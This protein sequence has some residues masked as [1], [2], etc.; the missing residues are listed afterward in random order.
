[1]RRNIALPILAGLL[2][3][4]ALGT[5]AAVL[6]ST[7]AVSAYDPPTESTGDAGLTLLDVLLLLVASVLELVG[8][9]IDPSA[10]SAGGGPGIGVLFVL[11][12]VFRSLA[13]PLLGIAIGGTV[14]LL[15]GRRLPAS[16]LDT[17]SAVIAN[18]TRTTERTARTNTNANAADSW[19]PAEPKTDVSDA[20]VTMTSKLEAA[21][22]HA[23]TPT[24]WAE[25]AITAGYDAAAVT[26]LTERFSRTRYGG[27]TETDEDRRAAR[28]ELDRIEERD[29]TEDRGQDEAEAE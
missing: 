27:V 25:D 26:A 5:A 17:V 18:W 9:E 11:G 20:W 14:L 24:E 2:S 4:A 15:V 12:S 16:T 13:L 3:I 21:R 19:P 23:R 6:D 22:P 1:M 10:F 28:R 8:I 29:C 7:P